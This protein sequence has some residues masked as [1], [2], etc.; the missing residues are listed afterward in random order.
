VRGLSGNWQFYRDAAE[1]SIWRTIMA[2]FALSFI[3]KGIILSLLGVL[4]ERLFVKYGLVRGDTITVILGCFFMAFCWQLV[5]S[6]GAYLLFWLA[7]SVLAPISLNRID[8]I[9]SLTKGTWWWKSENESK[10]Q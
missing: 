7:A 8:F 3:L 10:P 5:D 6:K 9:G 4:V 1:T 2:S